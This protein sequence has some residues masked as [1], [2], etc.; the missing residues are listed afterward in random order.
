[1]N[2]KSEI[3]GEYSEAEGQAISF[4]LKGSNFSIGADYL[5]DDF[6]PE[7]GD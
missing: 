4:L 5:V 7:T 2:D 1:V 3:V 6:Q